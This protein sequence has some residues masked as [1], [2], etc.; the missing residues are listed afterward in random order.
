[1]SPR[2]RLLLPA[3]TARLAVGAVELDD[4]PH[5]AGIIAI[6][7]GQPVSIRRNLSRLPLFHPQRMG[8]ATRRAAVT[9]VRCSAALAVAAPAAQARGIAPDTAG[10]HADRTRRRPRLTRPCRASK[11]SGGPLEAL[12][13]SRQQR[14][15]RDRCGHQPGALRAEGGPPSDP[16]LQLEALHHLDRARTLRTRRAPAHDRPVERSDHGQRQPGPLPPRW[17]RPDADHGRASNKLADRVRAAGVTTV[18]G[19]APLR[20]LVP[21]QPDRECRSTASPPR[22]SA[23]SRAF[24]STTG[25][26]AIRRRPRHS[27]FEDAL[28]KDGVSIG[29]SVVPATAPPGAIEVAGFRLPDDG[30]ASCRTP[31]SPRTTTWPRCCSRTSAAQFG[32]SGSTAGGIAVVQRFAAQQGARF[33]GENG[34]GLTRRNKASPKSVVKLLDSMIEVD[35]NDAPAGRASASSATPGSTRSPSP[36]AAAPWPTGCGAPP[37]GALPRQDRD[38]QRVSALSGYCFQG[39]EDA[40]HAV[41]FSLLMNRWTSTA[42]TWSRTGWR[43]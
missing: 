12:P 32:D 21:R 15:V 26:R 23:G 16:R 17:R 3:S 42:P 29:N 11:L 34:S 41:I 19:P 20:R 38:A 28:R 13:P 8:I 37:P 18:Q 40:D 27:D 25:P 22:A 31:T 33:A 4:F 9:L 30:R 43:P 36:G 39:A 24:R 14:R 2:P 1:M 7:A 35:E 10:G 5:W 6:P